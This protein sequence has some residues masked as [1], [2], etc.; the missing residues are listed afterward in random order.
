M[1][2]HNS[3]LALETVRLLKLPK[4]WNQNWWISLEETKI[5]QDLISR[6][7]IMY[8][9]SG[10]A[11]GYSACAAEATGIKVHTY[12]KTDRQKLWALPETGLRQGS[13]SFHHAKFHE[14]VPDLL[15]G[16]YPGP[17]VFFIDGEHAYKGVMEDWNAIKPYLYNGD[18][19]AFHDIYFARD[20]AGAAWEQIKHEMKGTS[21]TFAEYDTRCGMGVLTV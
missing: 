20:Q 9:E 21:C 14:S 13:I 19:V 8:I 6:D 12:D 2:Q 1:G 16:R 11:F 7:A 10:T 4:S 18:M 17:V 3:I 15:K 5:L